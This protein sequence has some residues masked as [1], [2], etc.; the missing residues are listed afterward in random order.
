MTFEQRRVVD[1]GVA[2]WSTKWPPGYESVCGKMSKRSFN[3]LSRDLVVE[4]PLLHGGIEDMEKKS[5]EKSPESFWQNAINVQTFAWYSNCGA[6]R[7]EQAAF[8]FPNGQEVD[9]GPTGLNAA[10][11]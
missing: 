2:F 6:R 1:G 8:P 3:N 10:V 7:A 5:E 9:W 4:V 11:R